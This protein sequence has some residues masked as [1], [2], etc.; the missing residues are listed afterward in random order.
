MFAAAGDEGAVVLEVTGFAA[1][2]D[3][4]V[5]LPREQLPGF[6]QPF[7]TT[8]PAANTKATIRKKYLLNINTSP[9]SVDLS[10]ATSA[11]SQGR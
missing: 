1:V 8:I 4:G 6:M 9:S 11:V 10:E 3:G 2:V 5:V 7:D